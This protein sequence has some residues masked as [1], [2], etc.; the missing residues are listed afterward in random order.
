ME[1]TRL[2]SRTLIKKQPTINPGRAGKLRSAEE[3]CK[4]ELFRQPARALIAI[5]YRDMQ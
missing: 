4:A 3:I 1:N 5:S 2:E